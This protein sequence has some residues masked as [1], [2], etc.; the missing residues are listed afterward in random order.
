M[1]RDL[2]QLGPGVGVAAS[3][4][5]G[6]ELCRQDSS[7]DVQPQPHFI[8]NVRREPQL[9][10]DEKQFLLFVERGDM[11]KTRRKLPLLPG[12]EPF[13]EDNENSNLPP[14]PRVPINI[15]C[16]DPLGKCQTH[17]SYHIFSH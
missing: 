6:D 17:P 10:P 13:E 3:A 8:S 11:A 9:T 1:E 7:N 15:N 2:H 4:A 16:T 14:I 5:I 12:D